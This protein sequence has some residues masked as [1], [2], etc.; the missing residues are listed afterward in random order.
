MGGAAPPAARRPTLRRSTARSISATP[1]TRSPAISSPSG[2]RTP[3]STICSACPHERLAPGLLQRGDEALAPPDHVFLFDRR[4]HR[5][6]AP[7]PFLLRHLD[8]AS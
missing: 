3:T 2:S 4:V 1:P 7:D 6:P 8:G 5:P